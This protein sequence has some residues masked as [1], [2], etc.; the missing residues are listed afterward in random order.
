M[1]VANWRKLEVPGTRYRVPGIGIFM[2][3][4]GRYEG[5]MSSLVAIGAKLRYRVLGTRY[6]AAGY[7]VAGYPVPGY[8][9]ANLDYRKVTCYVWWR[10]VQN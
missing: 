7:L 4:P 8:S 10:S 1:Q 9:L 3:E 5:N 2:D 6:P